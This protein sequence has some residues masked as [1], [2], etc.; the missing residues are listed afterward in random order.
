MSWPV[1]V[2]RTRSAVA[3]SAWRVSPRHSTG[4]VPPSGPTVAG[5]AVRAVRAQQVRR[6]ECGRQQ[7]R[8][9]RER[10]VCTGLFGEGD[11]GEDLAVREPGRPQTGRAGRAAGL[12][13]AVGVQVRRRVQLPVPGQI[14]GYGPG[15]RPES[16][17]GLQV[18]RRVP[19]RQHTGRVQGPRQIGGGLG[20]RV[21]GQRA[22]ARA[23]GAATVPVPVP[24]P[25]R[26]EGVRR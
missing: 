3:A 12:R 10:A 16:G 18:R 13:A 25:P 26:A 6:P 20:A 19:G 15:G 8:V 22:A 9:H 17:T 11:L 5:G 1:A 2:S 24:R 7:G 14:H 4:T 23:V 21:H